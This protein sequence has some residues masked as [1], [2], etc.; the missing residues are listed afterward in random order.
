MKPPY[1]EML[2]EK[3]CWLQCKECPLGEEFLKEL[4]NWSEINP[5]HPMLAWKICD[6]CYFDN[7]LPEKP[8]E[9]K[10]FL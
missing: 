3:Q 4:Y 5:L 6:P 7:K 2:K 1:A 8:E 9:W 10:R